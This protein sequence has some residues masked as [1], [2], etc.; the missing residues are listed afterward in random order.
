[1]NCDELKLILLDYV[2]R[3]KNPDLCEEFKA[4]N[5]ICPDCFNK[6]RFEVGLRDLFRNKVKAEPVSEEFIIEVKA[7]LKKLQSG[8]ALEEIG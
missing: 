4:H 2:D 7:Q 8:T 1:M 5:K 3:E 6:Y